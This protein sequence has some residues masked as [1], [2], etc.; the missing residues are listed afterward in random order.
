MQRPAIN[1][2]KSTFSDI[3]LQ[4]M[5]KSQDITDISPGLVSELKDQSGTY[6]IGVK[7]NP[8]LKVQPTPLIFR[9][10]RMTWNIARPTNAPIER[11]RFSFSVLSNSASSCG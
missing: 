6:G 10:D 11:F 5:S 1:V 9:P 2:F 7:E 3:W 4:Q 8:L